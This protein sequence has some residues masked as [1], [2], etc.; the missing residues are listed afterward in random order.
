MKVLARS[1]LVVVMLVSI[2]AAVTCMIDG[3]WI[4]MARHPGPCSGFLGDHR[5]IGPYRGDVG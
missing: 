5:V 2:A 3:Y 1:L 4:Q